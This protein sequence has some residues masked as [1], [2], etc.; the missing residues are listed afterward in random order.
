MTKPIKMTAVGDSLTFGTGAPEKKGFAWIV[1]EL[2]RSRQGTD[3]VHR[4]FGVVGATTSETLERLLTNAELRR[5]VAGADVVTLTAGGNDLI[6]AAMRMY[7][8]GETR[9]MKPGMRAFA[10]A[11]KDLL[12]ELVAVHRT[13][14]RDDARMIVTDCYNPFPQV[15]D[16]VLWINFVNRCIHRNAAAYGGKV[17]VARAYDA[18]LGREAHLFADDGVHPNERGHA[19]LADCVAGALDP[20]PEGWA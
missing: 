19:A 6:R 8:Q 9:S 2:W 4:N 16:A 5:A 11:Y 10:T 14:E 3:I 15:R 17:L 7:I 18:F 13:M 20:F 1:Q 12:G